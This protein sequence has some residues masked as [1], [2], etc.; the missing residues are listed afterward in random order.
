MLIS[1]ACLTLAL[2]DASASTSFED[3]PPGGF[4]RVEHELGTWS[5]PKGQAMIDGGHAREGSQCLRLV[6][7][8]GS[9]V[10]LE[11]RSRELHEVRF[12]AER[13]TRS[14]P[15]ECE[16]LVREGRRWRSVADLSGELAVGGFKTQVR[17]PVGAKVDALRLRCV[18]PP[19]KGVLID[20]LELLSPEPLRIERC[21]VAQ[22]SLPALVGGRAAVV[23]RVDLDCEGNLDAPSLKELEWDLAGSTCLEWVR[24]FEV[25]PATEAKPPRELSAAAKKLT[26]RQREGQAP[27]RSRLAA[28]LEAGRNSFWLLVELDAG[29]DLDARLD[30]GCSQVLLDDGTELEPEDS[31]PEGAQRLGVAFRDAGDDDVAVYRI[32]G[33]ATT[34]KGTLLGVFDLRWS[35]W[36]DLP[37]DVD[38]GVSRSTDG[39]RSWSKTETI[40]DMGDEARWGRDGVGDPCILVDRQTGDVHVFALWSHGNRGWAGSGP[41]LTPEET[42]QL[43]VTTSRDDG[44]SWS[45]PRSL[46]AEVKR[47]EWSLLFQG[48]GRG[49]CMADGTLVIPAQY[50]DTAE[51]K[52]MPRSTILWSRDHGES[53][54]LALG[55][56]T[57]TTEAAVVELEDGR[58]MLTCRDNRGGS[59]SIFTT[60]DLGQTW[61]EHATSRG[62]LV[63]P[64][65]MASLL[66]VGR[67]RDGRADGLL[68][69]CN[70]AVNRAPRRDMT[71]KLSADHG[72]TWPAERALLL[73]AGDSAG[74]S[75]LTLIDEAT[76][77]VLYEGSAS[78]LVFQRV[79]LAELLGE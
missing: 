14:E 66:H 61:S 76:V 26:R 4:E 57:N 29:A 18:S 74:Y 7:G 22:P 75:C 35:G 12:W 41:G 44:L 63:E 32:P 10:T 37:A 34:P 79:P 51:A 19:E 71:I 13:W 64:V 17:V 73:D 68:L 30:G 15:F 46:T 28:P 2:S 69:F 39:G 40:M 8:E 78:H 9:E 27:L 47:P 11:F 16:L 62:A 65:C 1:L 20:D 72:E 48:P 21:V 50:L 5:A 52:R 43:M 24:R 56:R 55:P 60:S 77:G 70:P 25:V 42:G 38:V 59:R 58:L 49:T 3:L 53:W 6:G 23:A 67:E 54:S 33:L 36:A 45:K 31:H